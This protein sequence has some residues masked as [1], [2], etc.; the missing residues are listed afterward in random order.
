MLGRAQL[1]HAVRGMHAMYSVNIPRSVGYSMRG[2]AVEE[3]MQD[4]A[5]S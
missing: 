5:R 4:A 2:V 3:I 1:A